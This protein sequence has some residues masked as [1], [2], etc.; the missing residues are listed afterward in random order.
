MT[1]DVHPSWRHTHAPDRPLHECRPWLPD[2]TSLLLY[3]PASETGEAWLHT[4]A[5]LDLRRW[6]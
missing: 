2:D 3:D 6:A 4:D 5:P 1:Q